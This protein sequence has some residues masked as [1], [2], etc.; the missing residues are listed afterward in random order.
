MNADS[1]NHDA[2]FDNEGLIDIAHN[3]YNAD[4]LRGSGYVCV[5]N[6]SGNT[7][8][9]LDSVD[10]CD[11]TPPSSAPYIDYNT[12]F[13]GAEV[14]WCDAGSPCAVGIQESN[15]ISSVHVYP[16]PASSMATIVFPNQEKQKTT[17]IITDISGKTIFMT[18]QVTDSKFIFNCENLKPGLYFCNIISESRTYCMKFIVE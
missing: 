6:N 2:N 1:T 9:I 17:I 11:A 12:G 4:T 7:G 10:I 14:T 15:V 18:D 3:F 13:V 8:A 5:D 16:V